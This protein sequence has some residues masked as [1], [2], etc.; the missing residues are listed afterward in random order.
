MSHKTNWLEIAEAYDTPENKGTDRQRT[1]AS[2]GL[3]FA[4]RQ[5]GI[6][7]SYDICFLPLYWPPSRY[8]GSHKREHDFYRR[9]LAI[10]FSCITEKEFKSLLREEK[11]SY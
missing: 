2:M 1:I 8:S 7:Y 10:L 4:G 6:K 11:N 5:L 3:C 9:D